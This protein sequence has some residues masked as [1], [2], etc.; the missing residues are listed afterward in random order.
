MLSG[1][2]EDCRN[3]P[4]IEPHTLAS[5]FCTADLP[6]IVHR[7]RPGKG[8]LK[9]FAESLG[10]VDGVLIV[11][12]EFD[13]IL[14]TLTSQVEK[15]QALLL[16]CSSQAIATSADKWSCGRVWEAQGIPTPPSV[17][18]HASHLPFPPPYLAFPLVLKLRDGAGSL[19]TVLIPDAASWP[20]AVSAVS[21][22]RPGGQWLAQ[23]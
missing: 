2:I 13:G 8:W 3:L 4:G 1:L 12:P 5:E 6:A 20:Q 7:A 21:A 14:E 9:S 16:G 18:V 22:E 17:L 15:S 10:Q 23:P 19:A 11:A